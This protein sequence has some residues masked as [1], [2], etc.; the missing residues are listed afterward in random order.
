VSVAAF[1]VASMERITTV[2]L[3][4]ACGVAC[5]VLCGACFCDSQSVAG[6]CMTLP[7]QLL[8]PLAQ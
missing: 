2:L 3:A 1:M 5:D 6:V 7:L 8:P 4:V